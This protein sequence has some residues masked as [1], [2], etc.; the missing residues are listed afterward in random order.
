MQNQLFCTPRVLSHMM[1]N[2]RTMVNRGAGQ[3]GLSSLVLCIGVIE[4]LIDS[5]PWSA[6]V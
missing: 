5:Y 1:T 6:L 4:V 3:A 2:L